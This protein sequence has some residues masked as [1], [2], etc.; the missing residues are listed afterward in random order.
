MA[1]F[2]KVFKLWLLLC[3]FSLCAAQSN[4]SSSLTVTVQNGTY[5]GR[6]LAE[7]WNQDLFLGMPYAQPP[8]GDLRF[9]WPQSLNSSFEGIRDASQYGYSCY[10]YG[11]TF[12]LSEDCL[13]INGICYPIRFSRS[14]HIDRGRRLTDDWLSAPFPIIPSS[15]TISLLSTHHILIFF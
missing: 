1:M 7:G 14:L 12:N 10:Q 9:R 5:Q 4:A 3:L 8:T 2:C 11:T 13:N 15:C 6:Y